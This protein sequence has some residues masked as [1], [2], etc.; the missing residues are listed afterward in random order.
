M[1]GD[2]YLGLVQH[3]CLQLKR[4]GHVQIEEEQTRDFAILVCSYC[5]MTD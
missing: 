3:Q 4:A 1:Q 2:W 5:I